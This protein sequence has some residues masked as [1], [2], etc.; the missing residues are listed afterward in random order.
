MTMRL[1][2]L[3]TRLRVVIAGLVIAAVLA[4][5]VPVA[6]AAWHAVQDGN[7]WSIKS[8]NDNTAIA[9]PDEKTARATAHKFNQI[10]DKADKRANK[11][12]KKGGKDK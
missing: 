7:N 3:H 1:S 8:G 2:S 4:A 6:M 9:M 12:D 11:G 10:E 5:S